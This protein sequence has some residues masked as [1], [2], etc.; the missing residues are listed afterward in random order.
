MTSDGSIQPP[1]RRF[2]YSTA[3]GLAAAAMIVA[4]VT[5]VLHA[6]VAMTGAPP[7][8]ESLTVAAVSYRQQ[9]SYERPVSYL[10]LVVAGRKAD[11]GFEIPGQIASLPPRQGTPVA[12]GDLIAALDDATLQAK[13]RA[14]AADLERVRA[15][16]ELARLK[17]DRQR[18]LQD[19]GAVSR[20]AFDE[21]RLRARALAAQVEAVSAQLASIDIELQKS[22]LVAPYAGVIA[23]RYVSQGAVV[24]PG[25]PVVRLVETTAQE[26]HIGIAPTRAARLVAGERHALT[27]RGNSFE[28]ELLSVRPDVDPV[29]RAA[30]AVFAL[31]PR[32]QA[33]DGEPVSLTLTETVRAVGGWLPIAALQEGQRGVWTVLKLKPEAGR[34]QAVREAVEVLDVQGD[35]AYVRGT[36]SPD[37]R[38]VARGVHRVPPGAAVVVEEDR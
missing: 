36:L 33:L 20:E 14:T 27:L 38:I 29:T 19:T 26:A 9:E 21:T 17:S 24:S 12:A 5:L 32:A 11:L 13:R 10:G 15:E 4:T 1:R 34:F 23:D 3:A 6:R 30:T 2:R 28:A 25:T 16:L 37:D 31:P 18:E 22:R 7:E 8:G 35:R